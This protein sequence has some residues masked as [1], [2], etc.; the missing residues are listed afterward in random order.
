MYR[1][2]TIKTGGCREVAVAKVAFS[3]GWSVM[4]RPTKSL[5]CNIMKCKEGHPN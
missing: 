3:G 4:I 1:L 5:K 2:S